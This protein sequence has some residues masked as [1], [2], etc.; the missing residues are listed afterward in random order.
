MIT[1][2][3]PTG[4]V[5]ATF[6]GIGAPIAIKIPDSVLAQGSEAAS[7]GDLLACST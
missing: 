3:D 7:L 1:G 2:T 6:N 5:V 4:A